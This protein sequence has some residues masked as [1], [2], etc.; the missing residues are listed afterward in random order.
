MN[1][2]VR[3]I[4]W[5][6]DDS[7]L[8]SCSA[9]GAVYDWNIQECKRERECVLKSCSY[10]SLAF[11]TDL[12]ATFAVGSDRTLKELNLHESSVSLKADWVW[13]HY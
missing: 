2:Q 7:H 6:S 4:K 9:D 12:R 10:T 8:I 1:F 11:T 13:P 3:C 5:S